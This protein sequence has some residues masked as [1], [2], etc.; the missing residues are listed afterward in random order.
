LQVQL[1]QF[2]RPSLLFLPLSNQPL[3]S[4]DQIV[5]LLHPGT[6]GPRGCCRR[7]L[8]FYF[9]GGSRIV[10]GEEDT[11]LEVVGQQFEKGAALDPVVYRFQDLEL[12]GEELGVGQG[13]A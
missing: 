3:A 11:C 10:A 12:E 9:F 4:S 7:A 1:S 8:L 5:H 13:E 2:H 6:I